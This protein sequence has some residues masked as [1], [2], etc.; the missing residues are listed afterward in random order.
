MPS[1]KPLPAFAALAVTIIPV[2]PAGGA[3]A[4]YLIPG[5]AGERFSGNLSGAWLLIAAR[6]GLAG[7]SRDRLRTLGIDGARIPTPSFQERF[8]AQ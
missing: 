1:P 2:G 6:F 5:H 8:H 3:P 4:L 7:D